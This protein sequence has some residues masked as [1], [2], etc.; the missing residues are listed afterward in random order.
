MN[1]LPRAVLFDL[2][3]TLSDTA[4][5]LGEALN[6]LRRR[7][8]LPD[9]PFDKIRPI[10]NHGANALIK[11]G[12]GID[13]NHSDHQI[14]RKAYLDA[15]AKCFDRKPLLFNNIDRMLRVLHQNDIAYGIV[16]NKPKKFTD[17]LVLKLGFTIKPQIVVSGDTLPFAKPHPAPLLYAAEK[18]QISPSECVYVGD[19]LRDIEAGKSAGMKTIL[20]TWGYIA[21]D[22]KTEEWQANYIAQNPFDILR[23]IGLHAN[24]QN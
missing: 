8:N 10:A 19:A 6:I 2:D 22:E 11:L 9:I 21:E 18:I 14:W 12:F 1:Q 4:H 3:G 15:Y 16:T 24:Y 20:A 13:E 23:Y 17:A 5:D 7:E